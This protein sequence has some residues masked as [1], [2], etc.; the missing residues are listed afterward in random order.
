MVKSIIKV[1]ADEYLGFDL[2][3]ISNSAGIALINNGD[4]SSIQL[5]LPPLEEQKQ[6]V[7]QIEREQQLVNANRELISIYEQK[8]KDEINK[9]WEN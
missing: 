8:I 4:I 3:L 5:P 2:S 1:L 7:A 9:L 6:I